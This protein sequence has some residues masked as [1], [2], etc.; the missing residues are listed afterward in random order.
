MHSRFLIIF[1]ICSLFSGVAMAIEEPEYQILFTHENYEIRKYSPKLL[2]EVLVEGDMDEASSKG[3][4]LIANYIFGNNRSVNASSSQMSSEK[5]TMTAPV[6]IEPQQSKETPSEKIAMTAPVT[7]EPN[8]KGGEM[9]AANQ[10]R[11][12]FVMPKQYTLSNIPKPVN[13]EIKLKEISEQYFVVYKYSGFNTL[14]KV[15]NRVDQALNWSK[16][17]GLMIIGTPQLSRYD[18]PWTLPIFRRNEIMIEI[19][20]PESSQLI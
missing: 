2:A 18:P 20:K 13:T 12:S 17:R 8:N 9:K 3:F 16:D 5:I 15:Q 10:W 14:S 19:S 4:R 1:F 7:I 11:V 6:T